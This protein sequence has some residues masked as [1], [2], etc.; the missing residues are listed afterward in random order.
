MPPLCSPRN[1]CSTCH[2][3]IHSNH[4][5]LFCNSCELFV[6]IKCNFLN[7]NDY[8]RF[9]KEGEDVPFF[10]IS[11]IS[12]NIPFSNLTKAELC[13]VNKA[14]NVPE[15]DSS[16]AF[17]AQKTPE[18]DNHINKL[19]AFLNNSLLPSDDDDSDRDIASP[20]NCNYFEP[21]EFCS[22]K[23]DSSKSFSML[24]L[25]IH[26]ITKHI[27]T[28]QTLL[29]T[30]ESKDFEF[31]IIAISES[32]IK[33]NSLPIVNVCI[34]NYH[35]P[36][37]CPSEANKGGVLLYVNKKIHN[38]KPRPD[39]CIYESK[40]IESSFIEIINNGRSNQIIGVIYR[41]PTLGV[42]RFTDDHMRPLI[43]KLSKESKKQITIAGDFNVNLLNL[44][45]SHSSDFFDLLTSNHLLPTISLPTKINTSGKN[46]LIDNIFTNVF[47]PDIISGNISLNI[48]DGHL[49]SF[50]IIPNPNQNH[51]PKHHNFFKHDSRNFNVKSED[52]PIHKFLMAQDLDLDW[53]NILK[54]ENL[55]PNF[56]FENFYSTI[57]PVISKFLP[58]KKVS[59]HE[60]KRKFK[61]WVSYG[62]RQC[63]KRRDKLYTQLRNCK[64]SIRKQ[65]IQDEYKVLRNRVSELLSIAKKNYFNRYFQ[66][67]NRNLRKIWQGINSIININTS[68]NDSPSCI[69]KKD[70][71]LI[72]D[73]T[74]VC[75]EFNNH[76]VN[77][78]SNILEERKSFEGDGNFRKFL[79]PSIVNSIVFDPIDAEEVCN[80]I[81][82]FNVNKGC[83]PFS[84]PSIVLFHMRH[85]L[86][87]PISWI[88]NICIMT[89]IHPDKLKLQKVIPFFK[90]GSKLSTANYR[91]ISLLSNINKIIEKLVFNRVLS[92]LN[93]NNVI[94]EKQF[95]F[96][97][98][99]STNH[100]LINIVDTISNAIDSGKLA[101]GVFVDF[102][103]AFD[104]V[105]HNILI[106]K[107][108]HYGIR[109]K[110]NDWFK[111]YLTNR[112]QCVSILGY[113]SSYQPIKYGVPQGSVLGPLLFLIYINDLNHSIQFS[114]TFHFADDTNLLN[115]NSSF[116]KLQSNLNKDL[117][118]LYRWL[119][120]N[121]ISLNAAKTELVIFRKPLQKIPPINIKING[122]R[123]AQTSSVKYLGIY[124]DEFL[125]GS[126]HCILLHSKLQRANGMLAKARHFLCNNTN[127]LLSLYYSIFS[128]HM[129]NGCQVFG[130]TD[131]KFV[132]KIQV[133]QNN[134]LRLIS[135]ADSFRDHVSHIYK[136]LNILKFRDFVSLQNLLF[137]H[138]YFNGL[139]PD[140]FDGYFTFLSDSH[141]H[142]T[143]NA[144]NGHLVV[145]RVES[146]RFGRKSFKVQST[147]LWNDIAAKF[148]QENF[149]NMPKSK[150]KNL[151]RNYFIRNYKSHVHIT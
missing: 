119:L 71:T 142:L 31:D 63:M 38:F 26:S 103:K 29:L 8:L 35:E 89:G 73:P 55:D 125:V 105:D 140:C 84:I 101:A 121:K 98:K 30:L 129:V 151:L 85:K 50:L 48:S 124:L 127:T 115:I 44:S 122:I 148:P 54:I 72:T 138:D 16:E 110:F 100:A 94:Y 107:L 24:H 133:L 92:F 5:A 21:D 11:C 36:L 87:K 97:P 56:S 93:R 123:I 51:L 90:K 34:D 75:E 27:E 61:P 150:F 1:P 14:I 135:F 60:H 81:S 144:T 80:L 64:N 134:A 130:Q 111:S 83:G 6:H 3:H 33:L 145:P 132:K 17:F 128:S 12:S 59:N 112:K 19:N 96:R 53:D 62:I 41:H 126:T 25:N 15:N 43:T 7:N 65:S 74:L 9:K 139:L 52:F 47:N 143:R 95:G 70:G 88:A 45:H 66:A 108:E 137:I 40:F 28:L 78:A 67:N 149:A 104:T 82:K 13:N 22:A 86:A 69:A 99:H 114:D 76:Y 4:R 20:I 113:E 46:T 42:D 10:C 141:S 58:L 102:Q 37:S 68:S 131:S 79:P 147:V 116:Y 2:K 118:G 91:P 106:S 117:K 39:L 32:K 57:S 136:N 120:A 109:G 23:F 18:I 77:V 49:P 146:D